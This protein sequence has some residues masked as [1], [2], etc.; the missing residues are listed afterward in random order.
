MSEPTSSESSP[1]AISSL[2]SGCGPTPCVAPAGPTTVLFGQALAPASPSAPPA[3]AKGMKTSATYGRLGSGSSASRALSASLASRLQ[4][5]TDMLGST[6]WDMTWKA[7]ATPSGR[8]VPRLVVSARPRSASACTSWSTPST[9]DWKDTA[10]MSAV[11]VNPDGS[12]RDRLDQLGRQVALASW[13]TR[14]H[15]AGE[16]STAFGLVRTGSGVVTLAVPAG[17]QLNPAHSR[18]LMGLPAAWDACAPTG[19]R[20]S[21]RSPRSSSGRTAQKGGF[22]GKV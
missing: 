1:S 6:L 11:G 7:S 14:A 22:D 10:G 2:V 16:P 13:A 21:R 15:L 8:Y 18:W 3:K 17:A 12:L 20:S 4:T 9:R 5:V 19:T